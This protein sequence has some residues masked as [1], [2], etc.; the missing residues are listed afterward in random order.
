MTYITSN[1]TL[2]TPCHVKNII[3]WSLK[4]AD[5]EQEAF[6]PLITA[7]IFTAM[8]FEG[9]ISFIGETVIPDW[10]ISPENGRAKSHESIGKKHKMARLA[11][12][13]SNDRNDYR[14]KAD[15]IDELFKFRDSLVHPQVIKET[16]LR[17]LDES[18]F[19]GLPSIPNI[20]WEQEVDKDLIERDFKL[21]E[22]YS[23]ELCDAAAN[24]LN[25]LSLEDYNATYPNNE[26]TANYYATNIRLLLVSSGSAF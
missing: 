8:M 16:A 10:N 2:S 3:R 7:R 21:V 26:M 25:S 20:A 5:Q 23:H 9:V 15:K 22:E 1:V 24:Y 6:Y 14:E 12:N 17:S 13:L 18:T 11:I 4:I 19:A